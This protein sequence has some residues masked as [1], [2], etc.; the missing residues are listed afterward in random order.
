MPLD[1]IPCEAVSYLHSEISSLKDSNKEINSNK[2]RICSL[3]WTLVLS[4]LA[5]WQQSLMGVL[6][7]SYTKYQPHMI[8]AINLQHVE[9]LSSKEWNKQNLRNALWQH[10]CAGILVLPPPLILLITSITFGRVEVSTQLH[11]QWI[12]LP[13]GARKPST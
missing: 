5:N 3:L 11:G 6:N 12:S 9:Q 4:G 1:N 10:I 2:S 8:S 13:Q 7:P